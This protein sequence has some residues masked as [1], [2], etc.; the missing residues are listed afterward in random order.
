MSENI[1]FIE[2][3]FS[4]PEAPNV[5][6][7]LLNDKRKFHTVKSLNLRHGESRIYS[8]VFVRI[9]KLKQ[10]KKRAEEPVLEAHK[11]GKKLEIN[12]IIQIKLIGKTAI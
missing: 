1:K 9:I 7:S 3:N 11:N 10:A 2:G 6:L 5:L 8:N 12:R 4:P